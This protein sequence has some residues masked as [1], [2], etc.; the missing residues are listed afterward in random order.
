MSEETGKWVVIGYRF[1]SDR[2][3]CGVYGLFDTEQE[4]LDYAEKYP[5]DF[6]MF[7]V[8]PVLNAFYEEV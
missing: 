7:G 3:P 6:D 1:Y 8:H 5:A 2:L 4:A